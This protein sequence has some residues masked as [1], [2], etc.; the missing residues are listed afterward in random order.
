MAAELDWGELRL[1][2][3]MV[4]GGA[5]SKSVG[6][7]SGTERSASISFSCAADLTFSAESWLQRHKNHF[8]PVVP[9]RNTKAKMSKKIIEQISSRINTF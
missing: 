1:E 8:D 9:N 2:E 4:T 7:N 5:I 6:C 3:G